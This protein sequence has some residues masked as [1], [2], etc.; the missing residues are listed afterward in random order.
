MVWVP[1]P[2][3]PPPMVW[4]TKGLCAKGL[5]A[6]REHVGG[7]VQSSLVQSV[8]C[9]NLASKPM[10]WPWL[11]Q[12]F[13]DLPG[14]HLLDMS[15]F[16]M[17]SRIGWRAASIVGSFLQRC[18]LCDEGTG[19]MIRDSDGIWQLWCSGCCLPLLPDDRP[20]RPPHLSLNSPGG[21]SVCRSDPD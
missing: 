11:V 4:W 1:R 5:C 8:C 20:W 13:V 18:D 2:P 9:T 16:L 6:D 19:V 21:P 10:P 14:K 12:E 3:A 15:H 17:K 7:A